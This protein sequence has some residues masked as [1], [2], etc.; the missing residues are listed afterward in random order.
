[1]FIINLTYKV[2]LDKVDEHLEAHIAYLKQ[3]YAQ[4]NFIASGRKIPRTGG[5]IL[6]K[7]KDRQEL[8]EI[9]AQ[10]PFNKHGLADYELIEFVPSMTS[11]AF[12]VLKEG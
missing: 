2:E 8:L 5:I 12:E 4:S 10:D 9:L 7:L 11:E 6:S 3:Q 1:M